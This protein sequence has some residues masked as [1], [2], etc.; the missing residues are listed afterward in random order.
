MDV[1]PDKPLHRNATVSLMGSV[2]CGPV[3]VVRELRNEGARLNGE[4][5]GK[6][7]DAVSR[8][9]AETRELLPVASAALFA[10]D[11]FAGTRALNPARKRTT[12]AR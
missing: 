9:P 3:A 8:R 4:G 7:A 10:P 11:F 1:S 2:S 12:G 5:D 6:D